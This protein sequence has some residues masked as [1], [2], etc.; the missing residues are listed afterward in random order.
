MEEENEIKARMNLLE[1]KQEIATIP[2]SCE[3][4]IEDTMTK[5]SDWLQNSS[6]K[7]LILPPCNSMFRRFIYQEVGKK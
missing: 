7:T 2:L 4:F 3:K 5:I 1:N 6:D